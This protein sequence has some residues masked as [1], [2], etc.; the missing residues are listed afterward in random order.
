MLTV[1][2]HALEF[3]MCKSGIH[4]AVLVSCIAPCPHSQPII[5]GL[6]DLFTH[7]WLVS[8][9]IIS[10]FILCVTSDSG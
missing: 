10:S 1:I 3:S 9:L 6:F 2:M 7:Q 8:L 4:A 5:I